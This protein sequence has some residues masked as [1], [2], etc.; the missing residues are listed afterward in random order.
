MG[1]DQSQPVILKDRLRQ[2][3][4]G[5]YVTVV[6]PIYPKAFLT[7]A[8]PYTIRMSPGYSLKQPNHDALFPPPSARTTSPNT[9]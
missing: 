4:T 6:L 1:E 2:P 7:S 8:I 5:L 9:T 3:H